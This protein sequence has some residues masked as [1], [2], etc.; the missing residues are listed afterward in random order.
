MKKINKNDSRWAR[1]RSRRKVLSVVDGVR[2]SKKSKRQED[3]KEIFEGSL[4]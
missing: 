1:N 4:P 2:A 3:K